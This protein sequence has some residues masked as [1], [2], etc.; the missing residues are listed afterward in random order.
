MTTTSVTSGVT[1]TFTVSNGDAFIVLSGGASLDSVVNG[2]G[3]LTLSG[4]VSTDTV[5]NTGGFEFVSSG[6]V[7]SG[8]VLSGGQQVIFSG[9]VATG[10]VVNSGGA[11][12]VSSGGVASGSV[13]SG[14]QQAILSGGFAIGTVIDSGGFEAVSAGGVAGGSVVNAGGSEQV[15]LGSVIGNLIAGGVQFISSGGSATGTTVS[16]AGG[17]DLVLTGATAT[18]SDLLAGGA[19]VVFAGGVIVSAI[20]GNG[21]NEVLSGGTASNSLVEGGGTESVLA[22]GL[23]VSATVQN[24]GSNTIVSGGFASATTISG[25]GFEIVSGGAAAFAVVSSGGTQVLSSGGLGSATILSGGQQTVLAGGVA[26]DTVVNSG[27]FQGVSAGGIAGASL[28]N[29]GGTVQVSLGSVIGNVVVGGLQFISS[30]G[31]ATGTTVSGPGGA[32]VVLTGGTAT[33]SVL[34]AGGSELVVTGG[35]VVSAIV[36][37]GGNEILSGGTA[38]NTT[39]LGGGT[40]TVQA[41]GFSVSATV[42]NGGSNTIASG[43]L[44]SATVISGGGTEIAFAGGGAAFAT[45]SNG[46]TQVLSGGFG[47]T[48]TILSGGF[49]FISSGGV[50]VGNIVS[51]G[52][53]EAVS[54]GGFAATTIINS[55][56]F[57]LIFSG[58][59]ASAVTV[60]GGGIQVVASGGTATATVVSSGAFQVVSNGGSIALTVLNNG[61]GIDLPGFAFVSGGSTADL[62]SITDVLTVTEGV[63]VIT[64]A[65]SGDYTGQF[66]HASPDAGTGTLITVDGTPCYCRGTRILTFHGEVAV[67]DLRIGDPIVTHKGETRRIRWIGRRS[68]AGRFAAG[69]REILPV[70]IRAGALAQGTPRRDLYV[71]PLHAMYLDDVLIP[72]GALVNGTSIV[73]A[74]SVDQVEYFHLEL[75]SHDIILAEGALS[76]TFV[77]D[78]SR[79][80][81]HNA[82]E[83]GMLYP[84]ARPERPRYCAPRLEDGERL[85]AVRRRLAERARPAAQDH[86][87]APEPSQL[88][89][90]VDITQRDRVSGWAYDEAAPD[91]P[92]RLRIFDNDVVIREVVADGYRPDLEAAG[93]GDGRHGFDLEIPGGLSPMVRHVIHVRGAADGQDLPNTPWTLEAEL[94]AAAVVVA[95]GPAEGGYEGC[96]DH[97]T[98]E[99]ITGWAWDPREPDA[100][101]A[102]QILDNGVPLARVLANLHRP[103]L[104]QVGVGN[105]R[106]G[107]DIMIPGALS[108]LARHVVQVRSERDGT[109]LAGSPFVIEPANSFDATLQLAVANAVASVAASGEQER[110]LSFILAQADRLRQQRADADA[111]RSERTTARQ[112]Q[113]RLGPDAPDGT[114]PARRAL[115]VD[116]RF[117]RMTRDYGSRAILSHIDALQRLGYEVSL[118]AADGFAASAEV[119]SELEGLGVACHRAPFYTSIEDVLR[120][121]A[122]CL[123]VIYLHGAEM[124][125]RYLTLAR[126]WCPRARIVYSVA[127]LNHVRLERQAAIEERP[128]LLTASRRMRLM[129][130]TAAWSA[131]AVITHSADEAALLRR[132]VPEANVHPVGWEIPVRTPAV[133]PR[134]RNGLAFVGS[135]AEPPNADAARWLVETIMPLVWL[136]D[137]DI[138]CLLVG[139]DMPASVRGLARPGVTVI[140]EVADLQAAV[141]DRV[142]LT[143][144]PQRHGAGING[145]VLAG[146]ASGVPCVMSD[147]AADGMTLPPALQRLVGRDE[148]A[149]AALICQ[150][151]KGEADYDMAVTAGLSMIAEQFN[152][153]VTTAALRAAVEGPRQLAGAAAKGS[154]ALAG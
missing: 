1:S 86:D 76:E 69:N 82:A 41:G 84:D 19:E 50:A 5:V 127:A 98:R 119:S 21:G 28:V 17:A 6:G 106:H 87:T 20:V 109:D 77:D 130:C 114:E 93:Y 79:G 59:A 90:C 85:E 153:A 89:G 58:G 101:A 149:I 103:D 33:G 14:G 12:I 121:Q 62:D 81:F 57:E 48:N 2:G 143:V 66:F 47:T 49:E 142:R 140:G 131:D 123:D 75:D 70:L 56:G 43:G 18:G 150:L 11:D 46:G 39:I 55:G 99:R 42:Q 74:G 31:S 122:D 45:V 147:V 3:F 111:K 10:T 65:L 7:A 115:V 152:A 51:V 126:D 78:D 80:M 107:F 22:G 61:G 102:L 128:E 117:P 63:G 116:S 138:E 83:F 37:S 13:L 129:E 72:A 26:L 16:G 25:G 137:P 146:L 154:S 134:N 23:S 118:A 136:T 32:D 133:P 148:A 52:G 151:H 94:P 38:S 9:G 124:A 15:S 40:E 120:R 108:P 29:A 8:S 97:V 53:E 30:G 132:L 100:P 96:V 36:S 35:V 54:A 73:Q 139:S 27:G 141:F 71:S 88:H 44:A 95:P 91:E 110:V 4:G 64:E 144:A 60:Q 145:N 24:G 113:R 92:V 68:Y 105:G 104:E 34:V 112:I 125:T 67:E 135:Y